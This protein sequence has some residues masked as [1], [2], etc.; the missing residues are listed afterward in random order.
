MFNKILIVED[1]QHL[2]DG[3]RFNLEAEGFEVEVAADGKI[4]L[5][6]LVTNDK[7]FDAI[8]LDV[9]LPKSTVLRCQKTAR[10]GE[11]HADSDAYRPKPPRRCLARI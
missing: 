5:D 4:A 9:M 8:V 3:L 10:V 7:T 2:A 6:I 11:F 1:E